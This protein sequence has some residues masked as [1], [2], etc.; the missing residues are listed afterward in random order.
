MNQL[1]AELSGFKHYK[2]TELTDDVEYGY[3]TE[4]DSVDESK[5]TAIE[6][7]IAVGCL[8]KYGETCL[9]YTSPSPR[10]GLLSRM[11]SSA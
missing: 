8:F 3:V 11:P 10:D 9:L 4:F 6:N 7:K 2:I 1:Q 5:I